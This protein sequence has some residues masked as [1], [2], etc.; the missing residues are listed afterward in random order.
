MLDP[1][2][3]GTSFQRVDASGRVLKSG[4]Y[5]KIFLP[6]ALG[7]GVPELGGGL[8]P[9]TVD[10]D[11]CEMFWACYAW[12][13]DS[14]G[15]GTR[16]FYV[17]HRGEIM[18]TKMDALTYDQATAPVWNAALTVVSGNMGDPLAPKIPAT[19][20]NTWAASSN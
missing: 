11:Q 15:T 7:V 20:G 5:F 17:D 14:G 1:P 13:V 19:D 12:P 8:P 16:A 6:D 3:L 9:A 18:Q 10:D 4:Y 2:L